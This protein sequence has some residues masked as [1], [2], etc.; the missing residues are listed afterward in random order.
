MSKP[1]AKEKNEMNEKEVQPAAV[2]PPAPEA[3]KKPRQ[4]L[5]EARVPLLLD[6]SLTVAKVAV[7]LAGALTAGVSAAAGASIPAVI[8]RGA[9]AMFSLAALFWTVNY[10]LARGTLEIARQEALTEMEKAREERPA[11]TVEVT[12]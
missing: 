3:P 8:L 7:L 10:L 2:N 5:K 11:S 1:A 4:L 12:A 9:A 6:F